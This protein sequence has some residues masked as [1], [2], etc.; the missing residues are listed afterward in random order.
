MDSVSNYNIV[1]S[2]GHGLIATRFS[3]DPDLDD[4]SLHF[5]EK[6]SCKV[7]NKG[8]M[9]IE[10]EVCERS[11]ALISSEKLTE[12]EHL[13]KEVPQNHAVYI[14]KDMHVSLHKLMEVK[15]YTLN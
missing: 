14:A 11:A 4:R 12:D 3:T 7:T 6:I 5:A 2:N 13:W 8:E 10:K 9:E 1:L 15:N